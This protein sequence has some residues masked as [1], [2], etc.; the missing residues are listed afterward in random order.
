MSVGGNHQLIGNVWEW[1][2]SN[3]GAPDDHTLRL[4]V[5]MRSL[6]GGA[7]DTYFENQATCHFQSGDNPLCRKH[8]IGFRLALGTCD[9][10]PE[11]GV[12]PAEEEDPAAFGNAEAEERAAV[13]V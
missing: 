12:V 10:A 2:A 3:F 4:P 6:R 5:P 13:A 11:V 8:N 9:V 1:T 7:Y